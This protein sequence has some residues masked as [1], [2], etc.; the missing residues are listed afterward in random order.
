MLKKRVDM[1]AYRSMRVVC[2]IYKRSFLNAKS[3]LLELYPQK[4]D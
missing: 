2:V 4:V 3:L 1:Q